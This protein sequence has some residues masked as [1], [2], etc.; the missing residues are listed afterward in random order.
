MKYLYTAIILLF[1][2]QG[3]AAAQEKAVSLI[4]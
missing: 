1:L 4:K 2:S 3:N